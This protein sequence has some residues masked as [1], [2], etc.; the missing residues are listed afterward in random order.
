MKRYEFQFS[1]N[2]QHTFEHLERPLQKRISKKIEFWEKTENPLAFGKALQGREQ[3]FAFRVGD[4]RIIVS[5]K[6]KTE[7][8]ILLVLKIGHRSEIYGD[9]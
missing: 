5:P 9:I 8:I 6:N 3:T 7:L 4:Y 2:A 1:P